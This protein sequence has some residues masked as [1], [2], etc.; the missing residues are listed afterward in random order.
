MK[1]IA[2]FLLLIAA[3]TQL[4]AQQLLQTQPNLKLNNG[5][6]NAFKPKADPLPQMLLTQPRADLSTNT[7]TV[8][9]YM[10]ISKTSSN[11]KMPIAPL[12]KQGINY[13]MLI[14]KEKIINPAE[15]PLTQPIP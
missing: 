12:G 11:D 8:Y 3:S 2:V 9:S 7:A 6:Q 4:K 15:Q 1:K 13:T 10:P 14:K 5:L